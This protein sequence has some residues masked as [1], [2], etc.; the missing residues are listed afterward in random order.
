MLKGIRK[1]PVHKTWTK[2]VV[3]RDWFRVPT[4]TPGPD[5]LKA[6][7]SLCQMLQPGQKVNG[8]TAKAKKR[9]QAAWTLASFFLRN[10]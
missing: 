5:G 1:I 7:V 8:F 2:Y 4:G 9:H 10:L 3:D 6:C